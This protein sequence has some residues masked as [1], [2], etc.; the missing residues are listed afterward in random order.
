MRRRER[1]KNECMR[2]KERETQG[3]GRRSRI[4]GK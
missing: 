2:E 3:G 1:K 4:E